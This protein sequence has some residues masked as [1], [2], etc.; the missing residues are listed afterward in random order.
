MSIACVCHR[1]AGV[2]CRLIGKE[3]V[4][5]TRAE[6]CIAP[7]DFAQFLSTCGNFIKHVKIHPKCKRRPSSVNTSPIPHCFL[8]H[9]SPSSI[10]EVQILPVSYF[11][12]WE[13]LK[14]FLEDCTNLRVVRLR[15]FYPRKERQFSLFHDTQSLHIWRSPISGRCLLGSS[16]LVDLSLTFCSKI[17]PKY[18]KN[19][20]KNN[21]KLKRLDIRRCYSLTNKSV[22]QALGNHKSIVRISLDIRFFEVSSVLPE[23]PNLKQIAI[24]ED[25]SLRPQHNPPIVDYPYKSLFQQFCDN[26]SSTLESLELHFWDFSLITNWPPFQSL[27]NLKLMFAKN[28]TKDLLKKVGESCKHLKEADLWHSMVD[29]TNEGLL[30]F[31]RASENLNRLDIRGNVWYSQNLISK[32]GE[33]RRDMSSTGPLTI[34]YNRNLRWIFPEDRVTQHDEPRKLV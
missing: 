14:S 30:D 10:E 12:M 31:I 28:L 25:C 16:N 34:L 27:T 11:F 33:I 32:I 22:G 17:K 7:A 19:V 4:D 15:C 1:F 21:K 9:C 23:L 24:F 13:K 6:K 26:H 20:L 29:V 3:V 5:L 18:F 2:I 8:K